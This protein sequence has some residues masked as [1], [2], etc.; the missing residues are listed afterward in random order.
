M[1]FV[2][3]ASLAVMD[4]LRLHTMLN[5]RDIVK[6]TGYSHSTIEITTKHLVKIGYLETRRE[7][8]SNIYKLTQTGYRASKLAVE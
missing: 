8:A 5:K 4:I 1:I 7:G 2:T 3:P 6:Y